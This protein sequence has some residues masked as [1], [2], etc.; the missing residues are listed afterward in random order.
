MAAAHQPKRIA[1]AFTLLEVLLVLAILAAAMAIAVPTYDSMIV[2]TRLQRSAELLELEMQRARVEAL[3]TGQSQ[4]FRFQVGGDS[5]TSEPWL[6]ANDSINAGPG[7]TVQSMSGQLVETSANPFDI[8]N[9]VE[10]TSTEMKLEE[11]IIFA[12]A[13]TLSD[14][15]SQMA[16]VEAGL[17]MQAG[18]SWSSPILFYA[19]GSSTTAEIIIKDDRGR[20]RAIQVRG[21]T[22][23]ARVIELPS[24]GAS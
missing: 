3:R 7:A 21:L 10:P 6:D 5:F 20:R 16:Q 13:D 23:Q 15:R 9:A 22:G 12:S 8:G 18:V 4:V 11:G 17:D 2:E 14:S 19:D 1:K 24:E